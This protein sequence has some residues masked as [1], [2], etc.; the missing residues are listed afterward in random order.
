MNIVM[1]GSLGHVGKP[2]TEELVRRGHRVTVVSSQARRR[3]EIEALGAQA[4]TGTLEDREFLTAVFQDADAVFLLLAPGGAFTDPR[5]DLDAKF[6]EVGEA[7]FGAIQASG[8]NRVVYLSS[9]G[10]H[11]P[12]G[13]GLLRLHHAMEARLDALNRVAV[14]FLRPTGFYTNLYA[15]VP[16]IQA[17]GVI[18]ADYGAEVLEW[19]SPADIA[20]AAAEELEAL[21]SGRPNPGARKVRYVASDELTGSQTAAI[22][23]EAM[24]KPDLKWVVVPGD[25]VREGMVAAGMNPSIADAM[26]EMNAARV[27]GRLSED[28]YRHRPV[29]GR[30][31]MAEFAREFATAYRRT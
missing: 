29:L 2:L 10:A 15:F 11:L 7:C 8:V 1:T 22:L 25:Q 23:G 18:A 28:Y 3:V 4:A 17:R 9:I 13:N 16:M 12:S 31:K 24:G 26:V 27:T 5:I 30:V 14:T 6:R 19:V 21:G 20:V